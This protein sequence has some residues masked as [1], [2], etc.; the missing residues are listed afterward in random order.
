MGRGEDLQMINDCV[1]DNG[2]LTYDER[3]GMS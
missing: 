3:M 2:Y 1:F